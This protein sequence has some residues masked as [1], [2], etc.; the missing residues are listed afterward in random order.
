MML[1]VLPP[2][3]IS[4]SSMLLSVSPI[5]P[6]KFLYQRCL[7]TFSISAP[8]EIT[9]CNLVIR[10]WTD[11]VPVWA[12]CLIFLVMYALLNYT[13]VSCYGEAEF[14]LSIGKVIL[15]TGLL[16]Y[17]FTVMLGGNPLHDRFGFRYWKNPGAF[18]ESSTTGDSGRF[19]GFV[20]CL[21]QA[22]FTIAGP[23]YGE[24]SERSD[25]QTHR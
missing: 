11:A 18:A 13:H 17:T 10:Y 14:R 6:R 8:F 9:V 21:V 12:V 4:S 22:A 20:Y 2:V 19:I 25:F 24:H 3:T 23:E 1:L 5:S 16:I 15:I 7:L